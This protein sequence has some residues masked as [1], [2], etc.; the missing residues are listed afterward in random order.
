MRLRICALCLLVSMCPMGVGGAPRQKKG[1]SDEQSRQAET[2]T[3][4][5]KS[6]ESLYEFYQKYWR[7]DSGGVAEGVSDSVAKLLAN[8]WSSTPDFVAL[9]DQDRDFEKFVLR[10]V[11][12]TIDQQHDA[13]KIRENAQSH[14]PENLQRL[15]KEL[16]T[17]AAP[18]RDM[19]PR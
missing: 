6:W 8:H 1:C 2:A 9:A 12:A 5:L 15:C 10:H 11:D 19:G 7:C 18:P 13:P 4:N 16:I 17:R 3:E 14:C